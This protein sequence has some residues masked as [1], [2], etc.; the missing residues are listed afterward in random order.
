MPKICSYGF[1]CASMLLQPGLT[2]ENCPNRLV[3]GTIIQLTEEEQAELYAARMENNRRIVQTVM[4]SPQRA[5]QRLLNDRG[6]PQ[7]AETIAVEE[8]TVNL[9]ARI[10]QCQ[11]MIAELTSSYVA[12][13]G[14]EAHRYLVKRPYATYQYNKLTSKEA[15]FPPQQEESYVKVLHLSSDTDPRNI[16]GRSGIE[17]RNR[18]LL[19]KTQIEKAAELLAK[20]IESI[21]ATSIEEVVTNKIFE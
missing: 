16:L 3:C 12:P 1:S 20:A 17:R 11:E 19:L 7:T 18:I 21:G 6:C 2:A 5:A 15:V 10:A 8:S 14:V 9:I 4:M 13:P